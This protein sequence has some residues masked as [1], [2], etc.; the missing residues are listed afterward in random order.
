MLYYKP[1]NFL[2]GRTGART[3]P[4]KATGR[5]QEWLDVPSAPPVTKLPRMSWHTVDR[6]NEGLAACW[7]HPQLNPRDTLGQGLS[8]MHFRNHQSLSL[9]L[10]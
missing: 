5:M 10:A 8:Q 2:S 7:T 3:L 9:S 4:P 6:G 1:W